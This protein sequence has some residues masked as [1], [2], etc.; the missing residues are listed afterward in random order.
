MLVPGILQT[1]DYAREL[2]HLPTGPAA[3][4]ASEEQISRMIASR[5][6][7]QA[8][9]HEPGRD[10]TIL[11]GEGA[12]RTRIASPPVM[13]AQRE[14]I[15]RLAETLTTARIA[16]VPFTAK[17]PIATLNGWGITDDLASI[18]TDAGELEIADPEHVE[19]YWHYTR[20]LLDIAATNDDAA[21][22]CRSINTATVDSTRVSRR[23]AFTD[24]SR[25]RRALAQ[26]GQARDGCSPI[27]LGNAGTA[28][29]HHVAPAAQ[30]LRATSRRLIAVGKGSRNR[31][32]RAGKRKD[33]PVTVATDDVFA[34]LLE[35][36]GAE[37]FAT[38]IRKHP[39]LLSDASIDQMRRYGDQPQ[40]GAAFVCAAQ[41][42]RDARRDPTTAWLAYRRAM[43]DLDALSAELAS[44]IDAIAAALDDHRPDDAISAAD[45][46]LPRAVDAGLNPAVAALLMRRGHAYLQRA[47]GSRSTNLEQAI[48]DWEYALEIVMEPESASAILLHLAIAY[49]ERLRGDRGDNHAHAIALLRQALALVPNDDHDRRAMIE[50]NLATTVLRHSTP[51][52]AAS[53]R[54]AVQLC[55]S[56]LSH[57]SPARDADDWAYTQLAI[58]PAIERLASFGDAQLDEA[59]AVYREVVQH[60]D[61][62][63][64]RWLVGAA[65]RDL[66]RLELRAADRSPEGMIDAHAAGR[67]AEYMDN[68]ADLRRAHDAFQCARP[69]VRDAPDQRL[70]GDVLAGLTDVHVRLGE[71]EDALATGHAALE[72]LRPDTA[73]KDCATTAS[74]VAGVLAQLARWEE[75]VVVY[76]LAIDAAELALSSR[77]DP[78]ARARDIRELGTTPRWAAFALARTGALREAALVLETGRTRELRRRFDAEAIDHRSLSD[79][80]KQMS[81]AYVRAAADLAAAPVGPGGALAARQYDEILA[82]IRGVPEFGDFGM[83]VSDAAIAAA[84]E[85]GW[86]VL[87]VNP[88]P[89]GALLLLIAVDGRGD[90]VP[91]VRILD[92]PNGTEVYNRL[93]TGDP[94]DTSQHSYLFA[95]GG[96]GQALT[97]DEFRATLD[98]TLPWIGEGLSKPIRML[99]AEAGAIGVT[100]IVSGPLAVVPL[101]AAPWV[102]D[103]H[104]R[105]LLDD[106]EIRLAPSAALAATALRRAADRGSRKPT[107]VGMANPIGDLPAAEPEVRE[108]AHAFTPGNVKLAIGRAATVAFLR[109]HASGADYLHL[110]CHARGGLFDS[111]DAAVKLADATISAFGLTELPTLTTRLVAISA[112]QSALSEIAGM[113]DEVISI[114]TSMIAMGSACSVASVWSVDDAATALLMIRLYD[115]MRSN[116]QRPPEALRRAQLWLRDL[117]VEEEDAFLDQHPAL[118]DEFHRRA[119]T[120]RPPGRRGFAGHS[121]SAPLRPYAHPDLWAPFVA[122]GV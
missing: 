116:G 30:T 65:Y 101:H 97:D 3:S 31:E 92:E 39:E 120:A 43:D 36:L 110:A 33:R 47:A 44:E 23:H 51:D 111:A 26:C 119:L 68:E 93:A 80:P 32:T 34:R 91:R 1:A 18:E 83:T 7:R 71:D 14:H 74:T 27:S 66:G 72:L 82:A 96:G 28:N 102:E 86:P 121:N 88:T 78:A 117:T 64:A 53:A 58:A 2:L 41:L 6:R 17:A 104:P 81:D 122:V 57:R 105:C 109:A 29:P 5:L 112:C 25:Q 21:T 89:A 9:L 11:I 106:L 90:I 75:A 48:A 70:H 35:P 52:D 114:C 45:I 67:F 100:L 95:V 12:L 24:R 118:R 10:I 107:F 16:I 56:A 77:L 115:E 60:R 113:P 19:R 62:I 73:P 13:H 63:H 49:A 4:G 59:R 94:D 22:L 8:I 15:A 42:L 55:R 76:R 61:A 46:S 84:C 69:L 37:G 85:P 40:I 99:L 103:G 54:E 20:L 98:Q 38:L 87:Y 108:I 50:T 79:L